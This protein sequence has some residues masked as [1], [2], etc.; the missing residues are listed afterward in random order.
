MC[1]LSANSFA[2]MTWVLFVLL[3]LCTAGFLTLCWLAATGRIAEPTKPAA[4]EFGAD[5]DAIA[6]ERDEAAKTRVRC[7]EAEAFHNDRIAAERF[8]PGFRPSGGADL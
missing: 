1:D 2:V 6:H 4:S 7:R 3:A 5:F 8:G